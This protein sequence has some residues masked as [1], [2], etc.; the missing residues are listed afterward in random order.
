MKNENVYL[1][2]LKLPE[3]YLTDIHVKLMLDKPGTLSKKEKQ[4]LKDLVT[5]L[6]LREIKNQDVRRDVLSND[7]AR[8]LKKCSTTNY[9][10]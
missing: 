9:F 7:F 5:I 6:E 10:H 2:K 1:K 3:K 4:W 8:S